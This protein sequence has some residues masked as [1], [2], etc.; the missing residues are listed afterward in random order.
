MF[1]AS[2]KH[3]PGHSRGNGWFLEPYIWRNLQIGGMRSHQHKSLG[4]IHCKRVSY[5]TLAK[6]GW[7]KIFTVKCP[8]CSMTALY[9]WHFILNA[10]LTQH[11]IHHSRVQVP[12]KINV[13]LLAQYFGHLFENFFSLWYFSTRK[14][15]VKLY[16]YMGWKKKKNADRERRG[17]DPLKE[18][19]LLGQ[20]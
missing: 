3:L 7:N 19:Q 14:G 17:E 9:S 13:V 10:V 6:L 18:R 11:C 1:G 16:S 4:P 8:E 15:S 5:Q 12:T 2:F 20:L